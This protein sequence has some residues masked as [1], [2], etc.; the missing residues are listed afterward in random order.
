MLDT[1]TLFYYVPLAKYIYVYLQ[2]VTRFDP[3]NIDTIDYDHNGAYLFTIY[4]CS[5]FV[6][7]DHQQRLS[8][9]CIS[10]CHS[11]IVKKKTR[12]KQTKEQKWQCKK[13]CLSHSNTI[14]VFNVLSIMHCCFCYCFYGF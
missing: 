3:L 10:V 5:V 13:G 12:A 1:C 11:R 4:K 8:L 9:L 14:T 2:N 7:M 6:S